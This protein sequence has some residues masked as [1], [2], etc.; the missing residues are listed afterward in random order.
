M[1]L[2]YRV[3]TLLPLLLLEACTSVK[4]PLQREPGYPPAWPDVASLGEECADL[5]GWYS[6]HGTAVDPEG[7]T[8]PVALTDILL[9]APAPDVESISLQ[10][11]TKRPPG[12]GKN[13]FSRLR[14]GLEQVEPGE[15]ELSDC[16][17]IDQAL[18]CPG[19][20]PSSSGG[21]GL[22]L[23][24]GQQNVWL[25]RGADGTLLVRIESQTSGIVL[26]VPIH[27]R[28]RLWARF[29]QAPSTTSSHDG[30]QTP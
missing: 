24:G 1:R 30:R 9:E 8:Q 16:F 14:L 17:C 7:V 22:G 4:A 19:L 18:F 28:S 27:S 12:R 11:V 10:V 3:I 5:A 23:I 20:N 26:V 2:A 29:Q 21:P 6:N 15:H 25:T 13:T